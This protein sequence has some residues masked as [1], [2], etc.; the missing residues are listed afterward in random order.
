MHST[1]H[2]Y[3][4]AHRCNNKG[5]L[6]QAIKWEA[7][8]IECDVIKERG[9]FYTSNAE[10]LSSWEHLDVYLDYACQQL[11]KGPGKNIALFIFELK[12]DAK[13]KLKASDI[14]YIRQQVQKKLLNPINAHLYPQ[15]RRGLYAFYTTHKGAQYAGEIEKAIADMPLH[16]YEGISYDAGIPFL[17]L[18]EP[19]STSPSEALKWRDAHHVTNFMYSAGSSA[20]DPSGATERRLEEAGELRRNHA[21]GVY[22]WVYNEP[23]GASIDIREYNIDGVLGNTND[24]YGWLPSYFY[25]YGLN[26]YNKVSRYDWPPFLLNKDPR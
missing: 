24:Q 5:W 4:M 21:F 17:D 18:G 10:F 11:Q 20:L 19:D 23:N 25:H 14:N 16:K 9:K 7:N 3:V 1:C 22:G 6:D 12:Y 8:G 15:E 26:A 2:I 13:D